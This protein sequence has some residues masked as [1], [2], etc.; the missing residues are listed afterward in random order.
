MGD[1]YLGQNNVVQTI[2]STDKSAIQ[3]V[4][5]RLLFLQINRNYFPS[6]IFSILLLIKNKNDNLGR[7]IEKYYTNF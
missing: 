1:T 2:T 7:L 4:M 3:E 5:R 6:T